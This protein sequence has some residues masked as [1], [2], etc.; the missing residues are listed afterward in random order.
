LKERLKERGDYKELD[1]GMVDISVMG[2]ING[3]ND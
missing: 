1:K 3:N 2:N